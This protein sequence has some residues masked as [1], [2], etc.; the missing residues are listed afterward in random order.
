MVKI[1][2][3]IGARPQFIKAATVSRAIGR[4]VQHENGEE[5]IHEIIVHTGQHYDENMSKVFFDDLK[6]PAPGYNL[7]VGSDSHGRQTGFM[8]SEIEDVLINE[9]PDLVLTYGDTN[10]TLAGALGAVKL[11][12]PTAHVEAGLRSY[13]RR[14]PEEIN[15][16][17]TDEVSS[18]LFC[19]TKTAVA[20]LAR[21]GI[22]GAVRQR[23]GHRLTIDTQ[24]VYNVGD[25][26]FDS[27]LFYRDFAEKKSDIMKRL[28][29]EKKKFFLA[30]VH[31]AE[32]TDDKERLKAI[33]SSF[34]EMHGRGERIVL[35]LHPRTRK[36]IEGLDIGGGAPIGKGL[37]IIDPIGYLDMVMLQMN[38]KGLFT[39][40]G[41]VQK[42]A[43]FLNVPCITLRD[44]TE[45]VETVDMGWNR[46][47]GADHE[48]IIWFYEKICDW[49]GLKAPFFEQSHIPKQDQKEWVGAYGD[50]KASDKIVESIVELM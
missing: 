10:S 40:S 39:D 42:E 41:G 11:H 50:G 21:E 34:E 3:I 36:M 29:L 1:V 25:V 27:V 44:E 9:R 5:G 6:I 37:D 47:A 38:A 2:T 4:H 28:K 16:I 31:R 8:L 32:N 23:P 12:I 19:P 48:K 22:P 30:T 15:R 45:W 33:L 18:I 26:M 49:D 46:L 20:N 24:V 43:Y 13:N 35:P 14:M 17:L 7:G